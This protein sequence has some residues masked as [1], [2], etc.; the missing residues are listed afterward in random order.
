MKLCNTILYRSIDY[1]IDTTWDV[2]PVKRKPD[3]FSHPAVDSSSDLRDGDALND[4]LGLVTRNT[5][6]FSNFSYDKII[7]LTT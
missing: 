2:L 7:N 1:Y 4:Q 3:T 5:V 6:N